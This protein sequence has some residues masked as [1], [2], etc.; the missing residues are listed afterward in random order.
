MQFDSLALPPDH[1]IT[2]SSI[3]YPVTLQPGDSIELT[4]S[5]C[6]RAEWVNDTAEL[7]AYGTAPCIITDTS[8]LRSIGY[9]PPW[10]IDLVIVDLGLLQLE[11]QM[12]A[13]P[14]GV[15]EDDLPLGEFGDVVVQLV[16]EINDG[17]FLELRAT[18]AGPAR[19]E[20]DLYARNTLLVR[21][22]VELTV[23]SDNQRRPAHEARQYVSGQ[24]AR[25]D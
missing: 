4:V 18:A 7:G 6:P 11:M 3:P 5:F 15:R 25:R 19:I 20:L 13:E 12:N 1:A 23:V 2:G 17:E 24:P 22:T 9:A 14:L 21:Q 10:P 16:V 8:R